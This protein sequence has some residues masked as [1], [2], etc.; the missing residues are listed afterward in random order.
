MVLES[1]EWSIHFY[2]HFVLFS[3][4][5]QFNHLTFWTISMA[6]ESTS[7][8]DKPEQ[9]PQENQVPELSFEQIAAGSRE[10]HIVFQGQTYRLQKTR[11]DRLILTK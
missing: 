4:R 2:K 1:R 7:P 10:V 9:P 8:A 6:Q 11:N 3:E 5:I